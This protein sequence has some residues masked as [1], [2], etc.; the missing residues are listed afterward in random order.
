MKTI[1]RDAVATA[2]MPYER[3]SVEPSLDNYKK[4]AEYVNY[5]EVTELLGDHTD[6][7]HS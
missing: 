1:N 3:R 7:S 4:F 5:A 6:N 2:P